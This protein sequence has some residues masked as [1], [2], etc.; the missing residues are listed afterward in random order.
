MNKLSFIAARFSRESSFHKSLRPF[1]EGHTEAKVA[2]RGGLLPCTPIVVTWRKAIAAAVAA[3]FVATVAWADATPSARDIM[4]KVAAARK[5]DGSEAVVTMTMYSRKGEKRERQLAMATK[6]YDDGKTEKRVYRFLSPAD[7]EGTGILV[8]DYESAADDMWI[9]LPSLHKVRRVVSSQRSNS[10]MGSEFSYADLNVPG[11]DDYK[12]QLVKE[13]AFR[14]DSC[15][16]IDVIP[17]SKDVAEGEGYSKKTYWVSKNTFTLR[18]GLYYD[19]AGKLLKE[20]VTDKI[21]LLDAK[22]KSYRPLHMEMVNKQNGRRS[23]FDTQKVAFTPNTDDANFT[24]R[25][26]EQL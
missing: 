15:W 16:V 3:M 21:K 11:L 10:F 24:T 14:G 20:L 25:R 12:Y 4:A 17:Q 8:F 9:Y 13:E 2:S 26:L 18:R 23:V 6:L 22:K 5:L 1:V 19:E 7:V